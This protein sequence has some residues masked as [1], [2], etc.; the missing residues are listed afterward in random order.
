VKKVDCI[1]TEQIRPDMT[2]AQKVRALHDYLALNTT[3]DEFYKGPVSMNPQ[4]P[5]TAIFQGWGTC[6]AYSGAFKIL[7]NAAGIESTVVYGESTAGRHT[8][9]QVKID[10]HW[11]NVDVTWDDPDIGD[12]ISYKWYCVSDDAFSEDH[13]PLAQCHVEECPESLN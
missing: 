12:V 2:E 5:R 1:I 7:L 4:Y 3:Y 10:G 11:Y 13:W 6:D 8:W 9:N